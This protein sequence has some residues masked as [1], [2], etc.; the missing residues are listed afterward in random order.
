MKYSPNLA[1]SGDSLDFGN[2]NILGESSPAISPTLGNTIAGISLTDVH[3]IYFTA[4]QL[5]VSPKNPK[6]LLKVPVILTINDGGLE[7]GPAEVKKRLNSGSLKYT[8]PQLLSWGASKSKFVVNIHAVDSETKETLHRRLEFETT[9]GEE[10]KNEIQYH[11]S[12]LVKKIDKPAT[13]RSP[14]SQKSMV[15]IKE[16]GE[17]GHAI[18]L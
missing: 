7:V 14:V 12:E 10:I 9:Q 8:Y 3:P 13:P 2:R 1:T 16:L 6:K 4:T 11:I 18:T 5:M 17:K 15:S